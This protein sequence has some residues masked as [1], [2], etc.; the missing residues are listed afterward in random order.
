[1]TMPDTSVASDLNQTLDVEIDLFSQFPLNPI[2]PVDSLSEAVDFLLGKVIH[3]GLRSDAG[4][5]ENLL[6]Q[7]TANTIDVL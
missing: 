5:S 2:L 1:M 4:L 7:C 3:L 6:A